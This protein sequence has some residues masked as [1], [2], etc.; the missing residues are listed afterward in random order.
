LFRLKFNND[1]SHRAGHTSPT[2]GT[3]PKAAAPEDHDCVVVANDVAWHPMRPE[4][5]SKRLEFVP[6]PV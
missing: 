5:V 6:L 4:R 3:R 1:D 2:K